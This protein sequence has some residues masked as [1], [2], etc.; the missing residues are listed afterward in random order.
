VDHHDV[1]R[2][3][4]VV[5]PGDWHR[6]S[7]VDAS[8]TVLA[9]LDHDVSRRG[10]WLAYI[11]SGEHPARVRV[12]G[13]ERIP[14]GATGLVR[15][16]L[17]EPLPLQPGDRFV[18]RESGR[19]ETV[20]G[21]EVLDVDPVLP[22]SK[23]RPDR[24]AARVVAERGWVEADRL[25]RLL[26]GVPPDG[27]GIAVGRWVV[28]PADYDRVAGDLRD[29]IDA[30]ELGLDVASLDERERAVLDTLAVPVVAGRARRV[31][32]GDPLA[33]HPFV[34]A[35]E[36]APFAPPDATGVDP[37]EL[38]ELVRRGAVV[39]RDGHHFAPGAVDAAARV[40]A[41]LLASH[42]EGV[43]AAQV[44]DAL[45]TTRKHAIPL[46]NILDAAGVTRRR[47]DLRIAG[48]RLPS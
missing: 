16:H 35:L 4:A 37:G 46:L 38:R 11:G 6:T 1:R 14:P 25:R 28:A 7:V 2:G 44:R 19:Q 33:S 23:A 8:F 36:A 13:P 40:V 12:L 42:P 10:A 18:L 5:R 24:D 22:A 27:A 20:G 32:G 39:E 17:D 29:R 45:G 47:G 34:A 21:G 30:S 3:D 48:P 41:T 43:S 26:G 31:G 9:S 15:L